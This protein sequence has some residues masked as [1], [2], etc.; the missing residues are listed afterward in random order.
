MLLGLLNLFI[1]AVAI[2]ATFSRDTN[3]LS[4]RCFLR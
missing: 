3:R 2:D 4:D 1:A